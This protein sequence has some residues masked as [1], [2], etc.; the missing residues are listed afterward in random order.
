M[1]VWLATLLVASLP[2]TAVAMEHG[3]THGAHAAKS[4]P[5]MEH[6]GGKHGGMA[7]GGDMIVVGEQEVEGVEAMVHLKDVAA[8]MAKMGMNHT[9]HLMVMFVDT[10]SG[11]PVEQGVAAVKIVDPAG[12]ESQAM[13]LVGMD[14]HFG[15]DIVL[16]T[17]GEYVFKVGT[18]LADAKKRQYEFKFTLK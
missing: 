7:M 10:A 18:K 16:G 17:A 9:H 15:A 4:D 3:D 2:M 6:K 5:M 11:E 13:P 1:I 12:R 14:G 8:D